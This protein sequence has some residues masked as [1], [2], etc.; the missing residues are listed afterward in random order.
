MGEDKIRCDVAVGQKIRNQ[1][2]SGKSKS[3]ADTRYS[4]GASVG[5]ACQ[6]ARDIATACRNSSLQALPEAK[7]RSLQACWLAV[8]ASGGPPEAKESKGKDS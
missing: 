2:T 1:V 3:Y 4:S 6:A 5:L 8:G 7:K